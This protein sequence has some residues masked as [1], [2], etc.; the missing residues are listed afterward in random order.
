MIESSLTKGVAVIEFLA[1]NWLWIAFATVMVAMH[2]RGGCGGHHHGPG[3]N[4]DHHEQHDDLS[5]RSARPTV[6]SHDTRR[7]P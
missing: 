6:S 1:A 3:R 4:H 7:V 5:S 2:R